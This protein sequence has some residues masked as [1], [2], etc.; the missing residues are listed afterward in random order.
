MK[1]EDLSGQYSWTDVFVKQ[2]GQWKA[3]AA[4]VTMVAKETK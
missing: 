3:V 4:Q 1:Q 2:N